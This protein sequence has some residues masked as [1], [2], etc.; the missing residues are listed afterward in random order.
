MPPPQAGFPGASKKNSRRFD[1]LKKVSILFPHRVPVLPFDTVITYNQVP[2]KNQQ[3]KAN[4]PMSLKLMERILLSILLSLWACVCAAQRQ[5]VSVDDLLT[6]SSLSPKNFDTYLGKRGFS[7]SVKTVRD[8]STAFTFVEKS[9][10]EEND[11][12]AQGR[13]VEMYKKDNTYYFALHTS[14]K[15]EFIEGRYQLKKAGFFY[16]NIKNTEAPSSLCFKKGSITVL[17]D[18]SIHDQS[19]MYN[20]LLQKKEFPNPGPLRF[21]EDLLKFDSHEHLVYFFGEEN[22]KEDVYQFS[23]TEKKKCSVLF[24]N[25]SQQAVFIWDDENNL[26]KISFIIIG[27]VVTTASAAQYSGS[28]GQNAW[29]LSN[30]VYSGMRLKDLLKANV[31]DFN[32]YGRNS[33]FAFMVE[34]KNTSRYIDFKRIGVMLDCFDCT[35]SILM[36]KEKV[37]AAEAADLDLAIYVSC[38]MI[39]PPQ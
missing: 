37:S 32:F 15:E 30:G 5:P 4:F 9:N 17:A 7:P 35:A 8:N 13:R 38:I 22:I 16:D 6:L 29:V 1:S 12:L 31:N 10:P 3:P 28:I 25:S 33:E 20:F 26:N 19:V 24:P 36:S 21:A 34:P 14:S 39:R 11:S 2:L 23:D 27:G 18:S